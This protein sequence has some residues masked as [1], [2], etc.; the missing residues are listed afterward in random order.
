M[1]AYECSGNIA[2]QVN[3]KKCGVIFKSFQELNHYFENADRLKK[4]VYEYRH[5]G[6]QIPGQ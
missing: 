2:D 5:S 6:S 1:I 4:D 3:Q